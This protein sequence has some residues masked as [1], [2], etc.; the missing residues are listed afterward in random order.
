MKFVFDSYPL[1]AISSSLREIT[2]G[3]IGSLALA[4][5]AY[6]SVPLYPTPIT[7]Q[8]LGVFVLGAFLGPKKGFFSGVLYLLEAGFGFPVLS[9]GHANPCWI[10]S[11]NAGFL[12][13]FP[14]AIAVSGYIFSYNRFSFKGSLIAICTAQALIDIL[15]VLVLTSYFGV[16]QALIVGWLP[17]VFPNLIKNMIA[18]GLVIAYK[19]GDK[20]LWHL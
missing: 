12:L 13:S 6:F 3:F 17:F 8:T 16:K 20:K 9:G 19:K 5:F 14:L 7:F 18:L 11:P 4:L 1:A 2:I 10:F 15:G